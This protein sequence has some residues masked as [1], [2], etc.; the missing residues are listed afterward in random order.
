M[1]SPQ[2]LLQEYLD[3]IENVIDSNPPK[4]D[5]KE[6][7][8]IRT[9]YFSSIGLINH[10]LLKTTETNARNR[11]TRLNKY[12]DSIVKVQDDTIKDL[13][14][15]L[16]DVKRKIHILQMANYELKK[17]IKNGYTRSSNP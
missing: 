1:N 12:I 16:V 14:N 10:G 17:K 13:N 6:L 5:L 15:K 9:M 4:K 7:R 8:R 11:R 2:E 3:G